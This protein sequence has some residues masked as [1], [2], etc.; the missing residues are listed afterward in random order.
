MTST[1]KLAAFAAFAL[2]AQISL[3]SA[4]PTSP[5]G[6]DPQKIACPKGM[7]ASD[8]GD[9][10]RVKSGRMG[11]DLAAPDDEGSPSSSSTGGNTR[12]IKPTHHH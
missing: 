3:A 8:D 7:V 9:C 1:T 2:V 5:A 11:F 4:D 6:A 12:S 10:V